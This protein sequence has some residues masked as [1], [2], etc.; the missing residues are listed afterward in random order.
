VLSVTKKSLDVS[1][2]RV[3]GSRPQDAAGV[4]D[5]PGGTPMPNVVDESSMQR[6]RTGNR[7]GDGQP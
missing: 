1:G 7:C 6:R 5:Q 3:V 4:N 2:V